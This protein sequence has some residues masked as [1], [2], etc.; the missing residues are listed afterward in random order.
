LDPFYNVRVEIDFRSKKSMW[1]RI[2]SLA[3][4]EEDWAY[5]VFIIEGL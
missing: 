1:D 2:K 5:L 4:I 3:D